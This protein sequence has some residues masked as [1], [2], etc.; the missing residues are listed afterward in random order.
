MEIKMAL[1]NVVRAS[2]IKYNEKYIQI[3]Y[4]KHS[5]KQKGRTETT[6]PYFSNTSLKRNITII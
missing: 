3:L 1:Q 2:N 6:Y 4:L 5:D